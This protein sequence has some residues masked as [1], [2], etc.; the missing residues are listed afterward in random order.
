[1]ITFSKVEDKVVAT[2]EGVQIAFIAVR[3]EG[4]G[5]FRI[6]FVEISEEFRGLGI[7]K[8]L[9]TNA[10]KLFGI[11]KL[12]SYSRNENSNPAYQKWVGENIAA[13]DKVLIKISKGN[14]CFSKK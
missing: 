5:S 6:E 10:F 9:L 2:I 7:Y 11:E 3:F 4:F 13:S 1:M 8:M 12:R 14:L